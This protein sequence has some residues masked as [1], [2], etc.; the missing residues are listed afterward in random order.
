[1]PERKDNQL[2]PGHTIVDVVLDA[3]EIE[4]P[5]VSVMTRTAASAY[6]GL[7]RKYFERFGQVEADG[8]GRCG[9]VI[10]PPRRGSFNL[11]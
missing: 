8:I 5:N 7:L 6:A 3:R 11:S 10:R 2:L 9:A 1:M 4:P